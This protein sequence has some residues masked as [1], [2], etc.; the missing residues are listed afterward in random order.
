MSRISPANSR[1]G[2]PASNPTPAKKPTGRKPG[3]QPGHK[4]H[5]RELLPPER[6]TATVTYIPETCRHCHHSLP[7][8]SGPDD[9]PPSR[10]QVIDL[11]PVIATVTEHQG[12]SRTCPCCGTVTRQPI[13]AAVMAHSVGPALT[14]VFG[15]MAGQLG[16]SKRNIEAFTATVFGAPVSLGTVSQLEREITVSLAAPHA[17]VAEAVKVAAVENV[18]ETG[19]KQNGG[20]RWLWIAVIR[21][22]C[23]FL[24]HPYRGAAA[25]RGLLGQDLTGIL[26]SDR[27]CVYDQW[28]DP[29]GRQLCW[30]HLKRNW[31][32]MVERGGSAKK[33]GEGCLAIQRAVFELWHRFRQR[34]ID[35]ETLDDLM[36]PHIEAMQEL[37]LKGSESPDARTAR[38]C[39]RL[40][41]Q[42]YGLWN[43]VTV[44]G[45]SRPTTRRNGRCGRP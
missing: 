37:L 33:V 12:H 31:E 29:F 23:L 13:P 34:E 18:D 8:E 6:V 17:E 14:G 4:P 40:V 26:C 45:W 43:F 32:A 3:G 9:P 11:P 42:S 1:P 27:W 21:S 25:M 22:A 7:A 20:K 35:R 30:A 5:L 28:P 16:M 41:R 15:Y 2:P 10:F 36:E 39:A 24:V 38:F 44:E 19:W